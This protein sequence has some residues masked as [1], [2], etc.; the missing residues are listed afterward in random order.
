MRQAD[1]PSCLRRHHGIAPRL[2]R[3]V[4]LVELM[5]GITVGMVVVV[6]MAALFASSSR[7]RSETE[8]TSH[9]I[10][11]GRYAL[12]ILAGEV[13][14][15]GYFAEFDPARLPLPALK[16]AACA[17]AAPDLLEALP[18]AAQG[19]DDVDAAT[20]AALPCLGDV[21]AGTDVLLLRRA[22]GCLQGA[23][24]CAVAPAGAPQFQL[25]AC[26]APAELLSADP[27]DHIRVGAGGAALDRTAA[28]CSTIAPAR[29]L[30][31]RIYFVAASDT[32]GDGV[33][34]LKRAELGASGFSTVSLVPGVENLQLEW[35][36][37]TDSDGAPD[38]YTAQ[39][40]GYLGCNATTQPTCVERWQQVVTVR[41]HVL[42]RSLEPSPGYRDTRSFALGRDASGQPR[43]ISAANDAFKRSVF[44]ET[45]RLYNPSGR[46]GT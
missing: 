29:R 26:D 43:T 46:R 32:A 12:E 2:A 31:V 28:N 40:D 20:L 3:G 37:D 33:P 38:A 41:L 25:S 44:Q 16:P 15:A 11:A 7:Q 36:L 21:L 30:W 8:R 17:Q 1:S 5:V 22:A 34:T 9:R 45:V 10:D 19:Y 23:V 18:L 6:A 4:T 39:V 13:Q 35:G 27:R 24:S 42:S 14:N